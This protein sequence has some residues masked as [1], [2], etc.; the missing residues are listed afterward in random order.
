MFFNRFSKFVKEVFNDDLCFFIV[1]DKV[2]IF[3]I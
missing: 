1:R 3:I 2:L